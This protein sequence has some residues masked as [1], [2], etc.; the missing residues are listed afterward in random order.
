[1][2]ATD[3]AAKLSH[4]RREKL[5]PPPPPR[6]RSDGGA[7]RV[8][9]NLHPTPERLRRSD[10]PLSGEGET[11]PAPLISLRRRHVD[12]A[13]R[14]AAE[15]VGPVHVLHIGLRMDVAAGRDRAHHIGDR[16]HRRIA[17]L[18]LERGAEAVVAE[19]GAYR[20]RRVLDP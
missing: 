19:L 4:S 3:R 20:L 8:G 5:G 13:G 2:M 14:G 11:V 10:P 7:V 9:V 17:A 12:R 18:A 6:G 16:E 1:T 15:T